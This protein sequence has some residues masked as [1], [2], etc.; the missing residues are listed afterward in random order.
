MPVRTR[1]SALARTVQDETFAG[2]ALGLGETFERDG[3]LEQAAAWFRCAA[4][5]GSPD[6]A[7]RLGDVLGRLADERRAGDSAENLLAEATRWLSGAPDTTSPD[8]IG[9]ITDLLN[10]HQR[11][12]ARRAT[13]E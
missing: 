11:R 13:E 2:V 8:A 4:E 6:A 10:R 5:A 3:D 7:L 1:P 12:A 9:L